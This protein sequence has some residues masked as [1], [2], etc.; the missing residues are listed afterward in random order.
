MKR[1][2]WLWSGLAGMLVSVVGFAQVSGGPVPVQDLQTGVVEAV[3]EEVLAPMPFEMQKRIDAIRAEVTGNLLVA[4]CNGLGEYST[5]QSAID[6]AS[7]GDTVLALPCVYQ[8]NISFLGKAI[9]V[10]SINPTNSATVDAT[11]IQGTGTGIGVM[12]AVTFGSQEGPDSVLTGFAVRVAVPVHPQIRTGVSVGSSWEGHSQN[13]TITWCKISNCFVGI[14]I[15]FNSGATIRNCIISNNGL[16][17]RAGVGG[18]ICEDAGTGHTCGPVLIK[19][20]LIYGNQTG[21]L[22]AGITAGNCTDLSVINCTIVDNVTTY[23]SPYYGGGCGISTIDSKLTLR[24]SILWHNTATQGTTKQISVTVY[25]YEQVDP[26][27]TD[28]GLT[29]IE[30]CVIDGGLQNGV[31]ARPGWGRLHWGP[32]ASTAPAFV[33]APNHNYRMAL[34]YDYPVYPYFDMGDPNYVPDPNEKDLDGL[35]R[36]DTGNCEGCRIDI[37]AYEYHVP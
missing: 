1:S 9:T 22:G 32:V 27:N 24:N 4:D 14:K 35:N 18:I 15:G 19:D 11:V 37:G 26:W 13:P 25:D 34:N 5:I 6:A 17:T 33:D 36:I 16:S 10:R 31:L 21:T 23:P 7:N 12:G 8:E 28:A 30:F 20:S 29:T 3:G 2:I